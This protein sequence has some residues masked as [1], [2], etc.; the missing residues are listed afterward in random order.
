[1]SETANLIITHQSPECVARMLEWWGRCVPAESIWIAYGGVEAQFQAL[2]GGQKFFLRS[3]RIRV[4]DPQR[5]RQGYQE[6]FQQAVACGALKGKTYVHLAEYDQL[7]LQP[8]LNARQTKLLTAQQ[9][10]VLGY[11]LRRID[12]T[13]SPHFLSHWND[14]EFRDF[15]QCLSVRENPR[16]VLSFVGFGSFWTA[17]AFQ[18]VAAVE[19]PLPIYLEIFMPTVAHHLGFRV[20]RI[21]EPEKYHALVGD[22]AHLRDEA[23]RAGLWNVHPVKSLWSTTT[24]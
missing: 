6:V 23:A 18:R 2:P 9:A 12:R 14:A 19:E 5:E 1:M 11:R 17:E 10:D 8:D 4:Q 21:E 3:P 15:L 20:R 7:P 13:N 16:T 24:T 22:T